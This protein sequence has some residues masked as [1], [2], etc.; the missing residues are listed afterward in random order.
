MRYA[1]KPWK[2]ESR[3]YYYVTG[4]WSRHILAQQAYLITR[5]RHY[6]TLSP[7]SLRAGMFTRQG[8]M[9]W[10]AEQRLGGYNSGSFHSSLQMA[11]PGA[12]AASLRSGVWE[13]YWAV[14]TTW[15]FRNYPLTAY[16]VTI[17]T[18]SQLC[19]HIVEGNWNWKW[20]E[21]IQNYPSREV[22]PRMKK[23]HRTKYVRTRY[24]TRT[25][26]IINPVHT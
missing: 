6:E 24:S 22:S 4:K 25:W 19:W 9:P 8:T 2:H 5:D 16:T 14:V 10:D 23:E 12:T 1:S 3:P 11:T 26:A 15:T 7:C 18:A 20:T 17:N 21:I 13:A